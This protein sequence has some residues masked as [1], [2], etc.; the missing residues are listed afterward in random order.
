MTSRRGKLVKKRKK[1]QNKFTTTYRGSNELALVTAI[2]IIH[3]PWHS[4]DASAAAKWFSPFFK[5]ILAVTDWLQ[6]CRTVE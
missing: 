6:M 1:K 5:R 3:P 2:V 4:F